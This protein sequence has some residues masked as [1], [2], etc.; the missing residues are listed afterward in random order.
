[1]IIMIVVIIIV[2]I[3]IVVMVIM[4]IMAIMVSMVNMII[5]TNTIVAFI[6]IVFIMVSMV[7]MD[8]TISSIIVL[9]VFSKTGYNRLQ[10]QRDHAHVHV[11]ITRMCLMMQ[12]RFENYKEYGDDEYHEYAESDV[13]GCY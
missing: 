7:I 10:D 8:F 9:V 11:N 6:I 12:R 5:M 2:V 1:M 3:S 4:I 13:D